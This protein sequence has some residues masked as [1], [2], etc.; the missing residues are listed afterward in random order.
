MRALAGFVLTNQVIPDKIDS[1][2]PSK[3]LMNDLSLEEKIELARHIMRLL[4]SWD[5]PSENQ[6]QMLALSE[7]TRT[8]HLSKYKKDTPFPDDKKIYERIFHFLGIEDALRTSYP[9]NAR[10]GP[11]W[12]N[13]PHR[14]FNQRTPVQTMLEDDLHGIVAVRVHLDCAYDWEMDEK[15]AKSMFSAKG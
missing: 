14:R 1:T 8:R 11:V 6:I 5:I 3:L 15:R 2:K 4:N 10:M 12:M 13:Q 7:D 9:H